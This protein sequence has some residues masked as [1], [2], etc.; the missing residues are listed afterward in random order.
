[1][2][3]R[4]GLRAL[5]RGHT[6]LARALLSS[7]LVCFTSALSP[8]QPALGQGCAARRRPAAGVSMPPSPMPLIPL[9]RGRSVSDVAAGGG[10][11]RR[12]STAA[13]SSP[14]AIRRTMRKAAQWPRLRC[15]GRRCEGAL[16]VIHA[17][18]QTWLRIVR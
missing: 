11:T 2:L 1:M 10:S 16:S 4:D 6:S 18:G 8:Q 5:M 14:L 17:P 15:E 12:D 7:F 3:R 9:A 13:S